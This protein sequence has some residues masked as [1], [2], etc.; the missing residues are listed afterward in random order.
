MVDPM[1]VVKVLEIIIKVAEVAKEIKETAVIV[2]SDGSPRGI[3][4][5]A[6]LDA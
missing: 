5:V 4:C 6:S 1:K 3:T 2:D